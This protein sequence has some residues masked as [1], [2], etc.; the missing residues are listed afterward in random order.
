MFFSINDTVFSVMP[1]NM[2]NIEPRILNIIIG[3]VFWGFL[4]IGIVMQVILARRRKMWIRRNHLWR[5]RNFTYSKVGI[6]A[7]AQNTFGC[8]AD[9]IL[10]LS[11]IILIIAAVLTKSAGY[12]CYAAL[13]V[14]VFAFCLHCILNGKIFYY[15]QNQNKILSEIEREQQSRKGE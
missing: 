9:V 8:I 14:F 10:G 1:L 6:L 15:I 3:S 4:I 13:A 12:V 5:N 2:P 7:F 11:L